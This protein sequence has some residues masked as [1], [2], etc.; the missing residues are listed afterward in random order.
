MPGSGCCRPSSL[1][2]ASL[3][4]ALFLSLLSASPS[5]LGFAW[6]FGRLRRCLLFAGVRRRCF[7]CCALCSLC[8]FLLLFARCLLCCWL[9]LLAC[10][11]AFFC[12]CLLSLWSCW[13][14]CCCRC[15]RRSSLPAGVVVVPP[16]CCPCAAVL[17]LLASLALLA[18]LFSH[19]GSFS[20]MGAWRCLAAWTFELVNSYAC[21][22]LGLRQK[23]CVCSLTQARSLTKSAPSLMVKTITKITSA[24]MAHINLYNNW[25]FPISV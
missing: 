6:L 11:V 9:L 12:L 4:A 5:P 19:V 17:P 25:C 15:C 22:M 7:F 24:L 18:A 13:F 1:V 20:V 14:C 21:R 8:P 3:L 10:L 23:V 16:C 2:P